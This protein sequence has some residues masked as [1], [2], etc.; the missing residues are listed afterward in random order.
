[1]KHRER[2]LI[3]LDFAFAYPYCD[4]E[5]YFPANPSSPD[6]REA[7][8]ELVDKTCTRDK[9]LYGGSFYLKSDAPFADYICFQTYTGT[10]FNN[11]RLRLTEEACKSLGTR[12]SCTFKCVGSDSVGIGSLAG[13]RLLH[14]L[15]NEPEERIPIWPFAPILEGQSAIVE[16]FP[17][18]YYVMADQDPIRWKERSCL[19]RVLDHYHSEPVSESVLIGTEDEADAVVSA[20]ALRHLAKESCVWSPTSM[21]QCAKEFE[22]W[23]FGVF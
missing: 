6:S 13:M 21:T 18:L 12:P 4:E 16:I 17:R 20:A 10:H 9:D 2:I 1:M 15:S 14:A 19:D 5:A 11:S 8:W 7:L 3:G 22:G 23:I